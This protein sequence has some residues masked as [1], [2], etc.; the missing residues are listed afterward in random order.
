M[1][2]AFQFGMRLLAPVVFIMFMNPILSARTVDHDKI[3]GFIEEGT[4]IRR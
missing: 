1:K 2:K 4:P 3:G